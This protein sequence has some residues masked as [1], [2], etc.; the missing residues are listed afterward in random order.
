MRYILARDAEADSVRLL[1]RYFASRSWR[2]SCVSDV[3]S[4]FDKDLVFVDEKY[5]HPDIPFG[6]VNL[7]FFACHPLHR[8][9]VLVRKHK[10]IDRLTDKRL[11]LPSVSHSDGFVPMKRSGLLVCDI[12]PISLKKNRLGLWKRPDKL[13]NNIISYLSRMVPRHPPVLLTGFIDND[14]ATVLKSTL[15]S[16]AMV[17]SDTELSAISKGVPVLTWSLERFFYF[18][19]EGLHPIPINSSLPRSFSVPSK[20]ATFGELMEKGY[21]PEAYARLQAY[22]Y[23]LSIENVLN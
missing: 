18:F 14:I 2:F 13:A 16:R 3:P 17:A 11:R 21:S 23:T 7:F 5:E 1:V 12:P 9:V 22:L 19:T 6:F 8:D 4:I 15:R 10:R 20:R